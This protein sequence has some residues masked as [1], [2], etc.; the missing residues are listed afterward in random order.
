MDPWVFFKTI[1][2]TAALIGMLSAVGWFLFATNKLESFRTRGAVAAK[3]K[4]TALY[5][6]A[7][8]QKKQ[9]YETTQRELR[10]SLNSCVSSSAATVVDIRN[11]IVDSEKALTQAE[12][13]FAEGAFAPWWDAIEHAANQL[14]KSDSGIKQIIQ[15]SKS[16]RDAVTKLDSEPPAFRAGI[17]TL[18]DTT[19]TADRM[20]AIVREAQ[21][22]FQFASIY[23][24][25]KTNKLLIMGFTNLADA[26][27]CM[28][29]RLGASIDALSDSLADIAETNRA[30][31][32]ELISSANKL[33]ER[34]EADS[35][36]QREHERDQ[37]EM[38]DNIQR[39]R[40]PRR[41]YPKTFD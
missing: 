35:S 5:E 22:N 13:E 29:E 30:N 41:V 12:H 20:R 15:Y 14:A 9:K 11:R 26:L 21:R 17:D 27:N 6:A 18:P 33:Y 37:R 34:M 40:R 10:D 19:R 16:Y 1:V 24:Q 31:T 4:R 3:R 36:A 23:E 8:R 32:E 38:L 7:G 2:K 25:R 28:S 39:G